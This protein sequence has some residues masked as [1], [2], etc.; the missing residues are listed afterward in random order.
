LN[1]ATGGDDDED[2]IITA[3]CTVHED[4]I[5]TAGCTV[6]RFASSSVPSHFSL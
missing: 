1:S 3:G 2:I 6:Q 5:I 4:I